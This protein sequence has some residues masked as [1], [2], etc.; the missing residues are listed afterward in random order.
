MDLK[1]ALRRDTEEKMARF[2]TEDLA[3]EHKMAQAFEQKRRDCIRSMC[4]IHSGDENELKRVVDL[5]KKRFVEEIHK[6]EIG[7]TDLARTLAAVMIKKHCDS[8]RADLLSMDASIFED[9]PRYTAYTTKVLGW[10]R[11]VCKK[12][13]VSIREQMDEAADEVVK[14]LAEID[15]V[16]EISRM[17]AEL[18]LSSDDYAKLVEKER[19]ERDEFLKTLWKLKNEQFEDAHERNKEVNSRLLTKLAELSPSIL[20]KRIEEDECDGI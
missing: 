9:I 6:Q 14:K 3:A 2:I 4:L 18:S 15:S 7:N 8:L 11:D 10:W 5:T 19:T 13:A 12:S 17:L 1:E 20:K 16:R